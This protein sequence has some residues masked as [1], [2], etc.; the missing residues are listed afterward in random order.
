MDA[1]RFL[2]LSIKV[3]I[4][5]QQ[6]ILIGREVVPSECASVTYTKHILSSLSK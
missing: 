4:S 2:F 5:E 3:S 1:D 6:C